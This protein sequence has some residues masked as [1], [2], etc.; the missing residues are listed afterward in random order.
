M[1]LDAEFEAC[2]DLFWVDVMRLTHQVQLTIII[3][4]QQIYTNPSKVHRLNS[5]VQFYVSYT[6]ILMLAKSESSL[7]ATEDS[8][9]ISQ[10]F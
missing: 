3:W 2:F 9:E 7:S 5:H 1:I 8:H 6:K 4:S 10:N